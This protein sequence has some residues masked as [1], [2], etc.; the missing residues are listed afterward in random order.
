MYENMI[1]GIELKTP[2]S[3]ISPDSSKASLNL[4]L[5]DSWSGTS[6]FLKQRVKIT[7]TMNTE[8]KKDSKDVNLKAFRVLGS[9][10]MKTGPKQNIEAQTISPWLL[11]WES[12]FYWSQEGKST[13]TSDSI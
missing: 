3:E 5:K 9:E 10:Q 4:A 11:C 12:V 2:S 7:R 8:M 1:N 13:P 6:L